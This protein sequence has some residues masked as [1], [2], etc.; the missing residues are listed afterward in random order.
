MKTD[1]DTKTNIN[2]IVPKDLHSEFKMAAIKLDKTMTTLIIDFIKKV[3]K[4]GKR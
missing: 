1:T 4:E 3:I 2:I